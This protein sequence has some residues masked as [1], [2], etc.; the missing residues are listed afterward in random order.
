M[1]GGIAV[2][3]VP[4]ETLRLTWEAP[5][6]CPDEV[7]L[8]AEVDHLIASSERL[9]LSGL[10]VEG[11]LTPD[12]ARWHLQ[13]LIRTSG[14]D[15]R[16][17]LHG[18]SCVALARA[19]ALIIALQVDPMA[20]AEAPVR[21]ASTEPEPEPNPASLQPSAF[22]QAV[23]SERPPPVDRG[24]RPTQPI[25]LAGSVAVSA[26]SA[27]EKLRFQLTLDSLLTE[28]V[29]PDLG[30]GIGLSFG[31]VGE[32]WQAR[33]GGRWTKPQSV[34]STVNEDDGARFAWWSGYAAV[35]ARLPMGR[36]S[37]T[38]LVEIEVGYLGG[39]AFGLTNARSDGSWWLSLGAGLHLQ[40]ELSEWLGLSLGA[41]LSAPLRSFRFE[42]NEGETLHEVT[43]T[44]LRSSFGVEVYFP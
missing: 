30:A 4:S 42:I 40:L 2:A 39:E 41:G 25:M 20:V 29:M 11:S 6:G 43:E 32:Y 27:G 3:Q 19:A 33:L 5:E 23:E 14:M 16:R 28:S 22:R 7:R 10:S 44:G 18:S 17:E 8:R 26:P 13:V 15:G 35:G 9:D 38:P 1:G 12:G 24:A 21:P 36:W 31:L 34:R 37:L